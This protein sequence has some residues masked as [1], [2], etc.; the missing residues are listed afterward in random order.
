MR[1]TTT[2]T[3]PT[4]TTTSAASAAKTA[5]AGE[6]VAMDR[7]GAL[8]GALRF[9]LLG[10]TDEDSHYY[11]SDDGAVEEEEEEEEE[12]AEEGAEREGLS[13]SSSSSSSSSS[14]PR[15]LRRWVRAFRASGELAV[16]H[17]DHGGQAGSEPAAAGAPAG[18]TPM[19]RCEAALRGAGRPD[20]SGPG[21]LSTCN[22]RL[23]EL[24]HDRKW[25]WESD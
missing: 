22:A 12:T 19:A 23:A 18:L 5:A 6:K 11:N 14:L 13:L 10:A 21:Y 7:E 16:N 15:Q 17:N 24:L 8:L 2:T 1:Q 9:A 3:T 25:L 20:G 4:T